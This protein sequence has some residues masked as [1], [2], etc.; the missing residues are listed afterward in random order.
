MVSLKENHGERQ[1]TP[2]TIPKTNLKRNLL[3]TPKKKIL[4]FKRL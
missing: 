3:E 1:E 2:K 4:P